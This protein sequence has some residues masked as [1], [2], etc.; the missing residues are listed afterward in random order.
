M[1]DPSPHPLG[2]DAL[3]LLVAGMAAAGESARH[4][5][6]RLYTP[7]EVVLGAVERWRGDPQ[8]IVGIRDDAALGI[9]FDMHGPVRGRLVMVAG[10]GVGGRLA[11]SLLRRTSTALDEGALEALSE[12]GNIVAS[13]FLNGLAHAAGLTLMPSV[14]LVAND[15][16][17]E[18]IRSI[19]PA[20]DLAFMAPFHI[21]LAS[22][23]VSGAFIAAPEAASIDRLVDGL[24]ARR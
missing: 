11:A 3:S 21:M 19:A 12:M 17:G 14:P 10:A 1:S 20:R 15:A 5:L 2:A 18:V 13:S 16:L 8:L 22:G 4:A 23:I 24:A 7:S 6:A 9:A